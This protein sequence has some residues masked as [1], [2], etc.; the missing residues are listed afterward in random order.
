M[1]HGIFSF[2]DDARESYT[3]MIDLVT[4]AEQALGEASP[5]SND[6]VEASALELAA[7][8][9]EVSQA[10]NRPMLAA[11]DGVC[12]VAALPNAVM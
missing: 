4:E 1:N 9:Y 12:K 2:A 5:V 11:F 8:R 3:R 10:A 7:I 6:T